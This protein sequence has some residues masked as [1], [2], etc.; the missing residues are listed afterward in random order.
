MQARIL[1]VSAALLLAGACSKSEQSKS[2]GGLAWQPMGY[3]QLSPAQKKALACCEAALR[4]EN[5]KPS[6]DDYNLECSGPASA[7]M[8]SGMNETWNDAACENNVKDRAS[9]LGAKT[10]AECKW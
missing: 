8:S 7:S 6:K 2:E 5:P 3:E 4:V 1:V 10:P 9:K